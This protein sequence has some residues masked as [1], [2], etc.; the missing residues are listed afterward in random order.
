MLPHPGVIALRRHS[1][2]L[3]GNA[4]VQ[5]ARRRMAAGQGEL[6][7]GLVVPGTGHEAGHITLDVIELI[8]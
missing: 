2:S 6:G 8:P 4:V 7:L 5:A 1:S 3:A